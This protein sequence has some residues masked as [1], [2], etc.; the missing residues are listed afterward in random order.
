MD[1]TQLTFMRIREWFRKNPKTTWGKN[2]L[3]KKLDDMET[4]IEN[5]KRR[6]NNY[7]GK[8]EEKQVKTNDNKNDTRTERLLHPETEEC[9]S[10]QRTAHRVG[11]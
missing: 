8:E 7:E 9:N 6:E 1:E 2:E 3:I 11:K 4:H 5:E 10:P